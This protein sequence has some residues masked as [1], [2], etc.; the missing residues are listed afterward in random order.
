MPAAT[1]PDSSSDASSVR[2]RS[3]APFTARPVAVV[4]RHDGDEAARALAGERP[5]PAHELPA[6]DRLVPP[7]RA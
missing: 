2:K 7:P 6:R 5:Q 4:L 3:R 1:I